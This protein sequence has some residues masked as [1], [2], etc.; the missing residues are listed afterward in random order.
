M[1]A[2]GQ[3]DGNMLGRFACAAQVLTH[4]ALDVGEIGFGAL[5][6]DRI[7]SH[8]MVCAILRDNGVITLLLQP[9][10]VRSKNLAKITADRFL[11]PLTSL[12]HIVSPL[13]FANLPVAGIV[14]EKTDGAR[15]YYRGT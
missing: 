9:V 5:A 2:L 3:R 8:A 11:A 4:L 7:A 12:G 6:H 13:T 14:E 15:E 10:R 1:A